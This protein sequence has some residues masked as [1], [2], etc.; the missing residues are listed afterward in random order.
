MSGWL[1]HLVVQSRTEKHG[2]RPATAMSRASAAVVGAGMPSIESEE[3][4]AAQ[5]T[6][7]PADT[8]RAARVQTARQP[9]APGSDAAPQRP[10]HTDRASP[11][12]QA[13]WNENSEGIVAAMVRNASRRQPAADETSP[14]P[15]ERVRRTGE[16]RLPDAAA[17]GEATL[18]RAPPL[19][20]E[21]STSTAAIR[22]S[23]PPR[24][25]AATREAAATEPSAPVP[26]V[27]IHIGRLELTAVTAPA[28]PRRERTASSHKPMSLEEYLRRR[29][30]GG[31]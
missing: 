7:S 19:R 1:L 25:A 27:H 24:A 29:D 23:L 12:G 30:G 8:G 21:T 16:A 14:S 9:A 3:F 4:V 10:V 2:V 5:P 17:R 18:E 31:R 26:D 22:P 6:P 13:P 20:R 15:G 28:P 11:N